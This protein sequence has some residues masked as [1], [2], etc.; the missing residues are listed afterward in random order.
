MADQTPPPDQIEEWM[1]D[2]ANK[3]KPRKRLIFNK[4]TK[5]LEMLSAGADN[6]DENLEFTAEE[7][8]RFE[9]RS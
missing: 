9:R 1:R 8:T 3:R 4:K 7:A 5:R 6:P 2:V